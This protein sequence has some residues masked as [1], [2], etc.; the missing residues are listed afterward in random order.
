MRIFLGIL[1][2]LIGGF[3]LGIALSSFIGV[4]GMILFNEPIG[5]KYLSY[6]TTIICAVIVPIIDKKQSEIK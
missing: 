5:I 1:V 4:L 2:G 6:F 3:V